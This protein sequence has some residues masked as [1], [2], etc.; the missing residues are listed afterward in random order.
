[1]TAPPG[2][3]AGPILLI[4][5]AAVCSFVIVIISGYA[6][7]APEEPSVPPTPIPIPDQTESAITEEAIV[8]VEVRGVEGDGPPSPGAV[9]LFQVVNPDR[10][11]ALAA[12]LA[13]GKAPSDGGEV[14]IM[15]DTQG[16]A[17]IPEA[18]SGSVI[19]VYAP[20][21][22]PGGQQGWTLRVEKFPLWCWPSEVDVARGPTISIVLEPK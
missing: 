1:M 13:T 3:S 22:Q 7:R 15:L 18:E 19:C 5:L 20:N 8:K 14:E 9:R 10:R 2:R 16:E 4:V 12:A 11:A 17:T 21:L 6:I